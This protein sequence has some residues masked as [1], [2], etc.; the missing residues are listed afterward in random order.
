MVAL[1]P[2]KEDNARSNRRF[3]YARFECT[4]VSEVIHENDDEVAPVEVRC[5]IIQKL[6]LFPWK[7]MSLGNERRGERRQRHSS[8]HW[9]YAS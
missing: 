5:R 2:S 8:S 6:E 3:S 1:P 9:S 7:T 4:T